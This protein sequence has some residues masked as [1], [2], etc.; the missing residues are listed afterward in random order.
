M[1][2]LQSKSASPSLLLAL[3]P[4]IIILRNQYIDPRLQQVRRRS[5]GNAS[6]KVATYIGRRNAPQLG[7]VYD[8]LLVNQEYI[9]QDPELNRA[10][11]QLIDS[12][13]TTMKLVHSHLQSDTSPSG[14]VDGRDLWNQGDLTGLARNRDAWQTVLAEPPYR[15]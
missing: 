12:S 13:E 7:K 9:R 15:Q 2:R 14:L 1:Q 6:E 4:S 11:G 10:A 3:E 8:V 5:V